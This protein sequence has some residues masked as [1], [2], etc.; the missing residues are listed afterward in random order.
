VALCGHPQRRPSSGY[1]RSVTNR[2][3]LAGRL[4]PL[5]ITPLR[6]AALA[7]AITEPAVRAGVHLE[8][9]LCDR[10]VA[11]DQRDDG[12]VALRQ[13]DRGEHQLVAADLDAEPVRF[14]QAPLV[15]RAIL[16]T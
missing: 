6:G 2:F 15:A 4:S 8:A 3:D 10:L 7:Q 14:D 5:T 13:P 1:F 12:L 11:D 9:R 16:A